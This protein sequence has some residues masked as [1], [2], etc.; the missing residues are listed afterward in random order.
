[1]DSV[2]D[3]LKRLEQLNVIGASLSR[4]RDI[5]RLLMNRGIRGN[6]RIVRRPLRVVQRQVRK[7]DGN[8]RRS[9]HGDVQRVIAQ[10]FEP[11]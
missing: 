10:D 7:T 2:S 11:Q 3:M 9:S 4:E 8:A 5:D 6:Q 1:M